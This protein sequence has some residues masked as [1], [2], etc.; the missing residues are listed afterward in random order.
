[1]FQALSE[2]ASEN[3]H[4]GSGGPGQMIKPSSKTPTKIA[5]DREPAVHQEWASFQDDVPTRECARENKNGILGR[6]P[7][8]SEV[9]IADACRIAIGASRRLISRQLGDLRATELNRRLTL[10]FSQ[11]GNSE[12]AKFAVP[13]PSPRRV[14][15]APG[16]AG[17]LVV[18]CVRKVSN[19]HEDGES[20]RA[21]SGPPFS[22]RS[23]PTVCRT[24]APRRQAGR[25]NIARG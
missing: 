20:E 2:G 8:H 11:I 4:L 13:S 1:M 16:M 23:F 6:T 22:Q 21:E 25:R 17:G 5:G 14:T 7:G 12:H 24:S 10:S 18:G 9:G 19:F 3:E 15:P